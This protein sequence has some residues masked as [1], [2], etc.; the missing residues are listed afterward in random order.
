MRHGADAGDGHEIAAQAGRLVVIRR[1]RNGGIAHRGEIKRIAIGRGFGREA[2]A[3]GAT[4]A[5]AVVHHHRLLEHGG[6]ALAHRAR[7][8]IGGAGR[9]EGQHQLDRVVRVVRGGGRRGGSGASGQGQQQASLCPLAPTENTG[10]PRRRA[11]T[12]K[13]LDKHDQGSS[14]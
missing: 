8:H 1:C 3:D 9:R 4:G 10:G 12:V 6:Q 2:H 11:G 14:G 13:R 7:Q 5:G